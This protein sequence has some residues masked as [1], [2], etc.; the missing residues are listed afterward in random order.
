VSDNGVIPRLSLN[1]LEST[2]FV[3]FIGICGDEHYFPFICHDHKQW[4]ITQ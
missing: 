1:R 3:M 2:E 4:L